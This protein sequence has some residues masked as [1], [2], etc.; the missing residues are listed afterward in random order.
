MRETTENH[1]TPMRNHWK[2]GWNHWIHWILIRE[3]N[4]YCVFLS[5][6]NSVGSVVLPMFSVVPHRCSVVLSGFP[7]VLLWNLLWDPGRRCLGEWGCILFTTIWASMC[8]LVCD[9]GVGVHT[10]SNYFGFDVFRGMGV[11]ICYND[12]GLSVQLFLLFL[13]D[14]S[15]SR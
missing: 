12:F 4:R 6:K 13:T 10:F 15:L 7:H 2:R 11:H 9:W 3:K 5:N 8:Y 14:T 1:W